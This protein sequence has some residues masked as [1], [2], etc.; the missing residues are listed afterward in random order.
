MEL[1]RQYIWDLIPLCSV[2][3]PVEERSLRMQRSREM[4]QNFARLVFKLMMLL[5]TASCCE[6]TKTD[7]LST[8][9]EIPL[10]DRDTPCYAFM[11]NLSLNPVSKRKADSIS[12]TLR[13]YDNKGTLYSEIMMHFSLLYLGAVVRTKFYTSYVDVEQSNS[14]QWH[15]LV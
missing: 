9:K 7:A 5:Q 10:P 2:A 3:L 13:C 8:V 12:N 14:I 11:V 1:N 4:E 6:A 15:L